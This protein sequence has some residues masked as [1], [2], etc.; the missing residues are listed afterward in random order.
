LKVFII[1]IGIIAVIICLNLILNRKKDTK[2]G[3][4]PEDIY[5]LW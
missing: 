2:D 3:E 5:P 4:P 1:V